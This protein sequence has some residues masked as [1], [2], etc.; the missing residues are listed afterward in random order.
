M[1][2]PKPASVKIV[3]ITSHWADGIIRETCILG[4]GDDQKI[5]CWKP[6]K[7]EWF[8]YQSEY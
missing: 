7:A 2:S 3:Q 1:E 8:L 4:L 5:Y 6:K